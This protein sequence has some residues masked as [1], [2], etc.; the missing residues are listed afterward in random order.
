M[1]TAIVFLLSILVTV[2]VFAQAPVNGTYKSTDL[3]GTMLTGRYSELW[4][5]GPLQVNNTV[6]EM[7]WDGATL[8]TQWHWYCPWILLPPTL[9]L[10]TV[11]GAGNG[12]KLWQVV[13]SGGFCWIDGGGPWGGGDPSYL[14]NIST[15][16]AIVDETY[17]GGVEVNTDKTI[18]SEATFVGYNDECM[19]LQV[20]NTQKLGDTNSGSLPPNFPN[21]WDWFACNDVGTAGPGEWG[22]VSEITFNVVGCE[23]VPVQERSWGNVK[24]MYRE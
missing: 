1:K 17:A 6:N 14:A 20:S 9:L 23:V 13:Y 22:D 5:G 3:A 2:P 19:S 21:F 10:D 18:S 8:G 7:S 12:S 24:Q 15:W 16:I 4:Y 11:D